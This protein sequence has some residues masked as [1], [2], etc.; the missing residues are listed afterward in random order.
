MGFSQQFAQTGALSCEHTI[1]A[2]HIILTRKIEN[3][4]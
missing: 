3:P 1:Q 2:Q 4:L